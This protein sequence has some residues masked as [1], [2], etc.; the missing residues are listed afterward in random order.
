MDQNIKGV[1]VSSEEV[2]DGSDGNPFR[3]NFTIRPL[4]CSAEQF[5]VWM[6]AVHCP[7]VVQCG[8]QGVNFAD[9]GGSGLDL[10]VGAVISLSWDCYI[11]GVIEFR[12]GCAANEIRVLCH[13]A[14]TWLNGRTQA[15]MAAVMS[16]T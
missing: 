8:N 2:G 13:E 3:T 12:Y 14:K 4:N 15:A 1:V 5:S 16:A 6:D 10:D 9:V 7:D 11:A